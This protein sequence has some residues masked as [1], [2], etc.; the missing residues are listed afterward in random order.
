MSPSGGPLRKLIRHR[1]DL[2]LVVEAAVELAFASAAIRLLPFRRILARASRAVNDRALTAVEREAIGTRVKWAV[3]VCAR[4]LPW[5]P[6]CFPQG[7]AAQQML[8]R[9]GVGSIFYYGAQIAE[10]GMKAHVW[11][12]DEGRPI[13]GGRVPA[14]MRVLLQAPPATAARALDAAA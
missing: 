13:V 14:D 10:E 7:L 8:R 9:R 11:V 5:R 4:R 1:R 6:L 2:P 12:C 3:M